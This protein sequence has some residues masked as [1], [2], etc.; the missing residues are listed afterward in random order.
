MIPPCGGNI[1]WL[2]GY[3]NVFAPVTHSAEA[4]SW[5]HSWVK[6]VCGVDIVVCHVSA[7]ESIE[8]T[9]LVA[10]GDLAGV[11]TFNAK[12][13]IVVNPER[14]WM[15]LATL[16]EMLPNLR[17][18]MKAAAS[19]PNSCVAFSSTMNGLTVAYALL[20]WFLLDVTNNRNI[21]GFNRLQCRIAHEYGALP[22]N[23]AWALN[24]VLS[25][26]MPIPPVYV[27]SLVAMRC[28]DKCWATAT[29]FPA[30]NAALRDG[31]RL[32]LLEPME[33]IKM[34]VLRVPYPEYGNHELTEFLYR[35]GLSVAKRLENGVIC[36]AGSTPEL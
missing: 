33:G 36:I 30:T 24:L 1:Q 17:D 21:W 26:P 25:P 35:R 34:Q 29:G 27:E 14:G 20:M 19:E 4:S 15:G 32:L 18:F 7:L 28:R 8:A 22:A 16:V 31:M 9:H 2:D 11:S 10:V 13:Q 6:S 3:E 23:R 5:R 12:S